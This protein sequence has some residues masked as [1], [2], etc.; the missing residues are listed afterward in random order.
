MCRESYFN[1]E[2]NQQDAQIVVTSLYFIYI[3]IYNDGPEAGL[4]SPKHVDH[5]QIQISF[6]NLWI[7]LVHFHII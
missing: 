6:K 4:D 1:M 5:P 3:Y 7:L 2:M